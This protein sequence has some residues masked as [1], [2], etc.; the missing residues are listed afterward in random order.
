MSL[1]VSSPDGEEASSALGSVGTLIH[2]ETAP[3][4]THISLSGLRISLKS[5]VSLPSSQV[6]SYFNFTT[7]G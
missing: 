7:I 5:L 6:E 2:I 4:A 1:S 3:L